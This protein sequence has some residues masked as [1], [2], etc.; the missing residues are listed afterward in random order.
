MISLDDKIAALEAEILKARLGRREPGS[1]LQRQYEFLKSIAAE[2]RA[3]QPLPRSNTLGSIERELELLQKSR[4][5]LGYEQ[6]RAMELVNVVVKKWPVTRQA[7]E[8][9]GEGSA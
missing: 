8:Q 7:L 6:G 1:P 3:R 5:A 4:T 9:F 2:H